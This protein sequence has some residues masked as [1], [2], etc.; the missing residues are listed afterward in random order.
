MLFPLVE[1]AFPLLLSG[2]PLLFLEVPSDLFLLLPD[3]CYRLYHIL[4]PHLSESTLE[5]VSFS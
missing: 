2:K 4:L 3:S 1:Y 5:N